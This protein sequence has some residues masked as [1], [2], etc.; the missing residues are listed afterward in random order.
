MSSHK[1]LYLYN[2]MADSICDFI[3][4][5]NIFIVGKDSLHNI[6]IARSDKLFVLDPV[7]LSRGKIVFTAPTGG[8]ER[9]NNYSS[10]NVAFDKSS[11]WMVY[12]NENNRSDEIQRI[13]GSGALLR[14]PLPE[15]MTSFDIGNIM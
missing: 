7:N 10:V 4:G 13:P 8:Y 12:R 1:G 3:A 11:I 15:Q 2:I 5:A 14:I 9:A 6:W